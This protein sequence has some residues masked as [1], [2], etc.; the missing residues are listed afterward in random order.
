MS[1][2]PPRPLVLRLLEAIEYLARR[3][4]IKHDD[5]WFD[6]LEPLCKQARDAL[7]GKEAHK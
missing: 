5:I 2:T 3:Y 6:W 1:E 4:D 7:A